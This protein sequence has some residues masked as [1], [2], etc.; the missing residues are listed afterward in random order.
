MIPEG[1][2]MRHPLTI[3]APAVLLVLL[4]AACSS[5]QGQEAAASTL[6]PPLLTARTAAGYSL[7]P[8]Y[9]VSYGSVA[10]DMVLLRESYGLPVLVWRELATGSVGPLCGL[11][12]ELP[13]CSDTGT[14]VAT[15]PGFACVDDVG[16]LHR[17]GAKATTACSYRLLLKEGSLACFATPASCG[18]A[19]EKCLATTNIGKPQVIV[20]P[21]ELVPA[22]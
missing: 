14:A 8:V 9:A 11:C 2:F 15:Q 17:P 20:G 21:I 3:A 5:A 18:V 7:G 6:A 22:T 16:D 13:D 1:L 19:G 4:H 12:H 10:S